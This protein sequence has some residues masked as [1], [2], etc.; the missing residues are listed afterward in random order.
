MVSSISDDDSKFGS[1]PANV[2]PATR[3]GTEMDMAGVILGM[4]SRAG[5]YYNGESNVVQ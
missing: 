2:I 3:K 1:V 4:V 5:A